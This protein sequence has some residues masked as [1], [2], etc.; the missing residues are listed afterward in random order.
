[1]PIKSWKREFMPVSAAKAAKGTWLEALLHARLKWSGFKPENRIKHNVAP[2]DLFWEVDGA[3]DCSLCIKSAGDDGHGPQ[4]EV[5]PLTK[6]NPHG[7]ACWGGPDGVVAGAT[8]PYGRWRIAHNPQPMIDLIDKAIRQE[9]RRMRR[10]AKK[11]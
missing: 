7:R 10:H 2:S 3:D 5:C 4:C 1:M 6:A 11:A 9:K 8:S